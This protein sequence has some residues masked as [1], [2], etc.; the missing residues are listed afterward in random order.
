MHGT[1]S[2]EFTKWLI[3]IIKLSI[4]LIIHKECEYKMYLQN[5]SN[6]T[7][8]SPNISIVPYSMWWSC[9]WQQ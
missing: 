9:K 4:L 8:F 6:T 7:K 3:Y 1:T 5:I 2:K